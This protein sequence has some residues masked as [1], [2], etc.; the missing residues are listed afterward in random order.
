MATVSK[1]FETLQAGKKAFKQG[2]DIHGKVMELHGNIQ[3][4]IPLSKDIPKNRVKFLQAGKTAIKQRHEIHGKA[5]ELHGQVMDVH[6]QVM[7]IQGQ[8]QEAKQ[9]TPENASNFKNERKGY[10]RGCL[11]G[12]WAILKAEAKKYFTYVFSLIIFA[13]ITIGLICFFIPVLWH[14]EHLQLLTL[15]TKAKVPGV[16]RRGNLNL[17]DE[18]IDYRI[19][20]LHYCVSGLTA[21]AGKQFNMENGCHH[22]TQALYDH[23]LPAI[24]TTFT[25]SLAAKDVLGPSM[26]IQALFKHYGY[27]SFYLYIFDIILMPIV[28]GGFIWW[29]ISTL[30]PWKRIFRAF[31]CPPASTSSRNQIYSTYSAS[32]SPGVSSS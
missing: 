18:N 8:F 3:E 29:F 14:H 6:G 17:T 11:C 9:Q 4:V 26:D 28:A 2:K 27:I 20:L 15:K 7:G 32:T 23:I 30:K 10:A 22:S 5:R 13:I 19:Y 1:A 12:C 16:T 24:S 31:L 21:Q 25:P